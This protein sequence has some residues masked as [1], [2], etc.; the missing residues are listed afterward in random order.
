MQP[1]ALDTHALTRLREVRRKL[2]RLWDRAAIAVADGNEELARLALH[3]HQVLAGELASLNQVLETHALRPRMLERIEAVDR[4]LE[5]SLRE[6]AR[7][8]TS[9][10]HL[11]PTVRF[12]PVV[13][14]QLAYMVRKPR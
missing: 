11:P 13:E 12:D 6:L 9:E 5:A 3:R 8:C 10:L 2:P 7:L 14:A 4:L 1:R